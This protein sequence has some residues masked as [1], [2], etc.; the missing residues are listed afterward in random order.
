MIKIKKVP[1]LPIIE[2]FRF[3]RANCLYLI[4]AFPDMCIVHRV[5]CVADTLPHDIL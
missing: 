4:V 1:R 2:V 5:S 3:K